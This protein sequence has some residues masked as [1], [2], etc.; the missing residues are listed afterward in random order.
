[1]EVTPMTYLEIYCPALVLEML[2]L[3]ELCSE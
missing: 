2:E 3:A 1:M